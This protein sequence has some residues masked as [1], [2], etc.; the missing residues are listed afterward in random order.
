VRQGPDGQAAQAA[1]QMTD[2]ERRSFIATMV[3]ARASKAAA[4]PKDLGANLSLA[5]VR[6]MTGDISGAR[7]ALARLEPAH[8]GDGLVSA[9][10]AAARTGVDAGRNDAAVSAPAPSPGG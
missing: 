2:A 8:P 5:R 9:I 6:A 1:G 4:N 7:A 10:V 3:A